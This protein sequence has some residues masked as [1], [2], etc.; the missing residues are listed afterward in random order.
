VKIIGDSHFKGSA[1][2]LNQYLNTKFEICSLIKSG[3]RANHLVLSQEKE[4]KCLGKN[5]VTFI[6]GGSNDIDRSNSKESGILALMIHFIQKYNNTNIIILN[7]PH[8]HNLA[9]VAKINSCI[10]AYNSKLKN[11]LKAFKHVS[12]VEMSTNRR[13]FTKHGFHLN[14]FGK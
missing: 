7:I 13:H 12:L 14:N 6:R 9:N 11:I 2:R 3:A 8:R 1:T 4:L 10:Q 5:D